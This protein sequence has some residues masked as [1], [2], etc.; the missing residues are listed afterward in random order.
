[1]QTPC[2]LCGASAERLFHRHDAFQAPA[3]FDVYQCANCDTNFAAPMAVDA[4]IYELIYRNA[5][6]VPGYAR[7]ER[8]RAQLKSGTDALGFLSK[9]E[10][11][12][13][14]IAEVLRQ[15]NPQPKS[16][17]RILE[18]G[19]GLGYLTYS[20]HQAG[21]DCRGIDLSAQAV[22]T[23]RSHFGDLYAVSDL[24]ELAKTDAGGYDFLIATELIEH[25]TAPNAFIEQAVR[26]L[27]PGGALIL[28]TPN[29]EMYSSRYVWHTD[30]APVH[31]WWFSKAS[32]RRMAW[33]HGL[34]V[35]F[36]DFSG[37]YGVPA[38]AKHGATKPQTFDQNGAIVFR[39]S[40][41]NTFVRSCLER[42]PALFGLIAKAY[43]SVRALGRM[44]SDRYRESMSLC[45]V[46]Q[47]PGT[48]T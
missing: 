33:Q 24:L 10:D 47:K 26:L 31:L 35:R 43:I 27:K 25:V 20:L 41:F 11:I 17:C 22:T 14:S 32:L 9:Q 3:T 5:S 28:T 18:V 36:V 23:A 1:M 29:K 44:R 7:Y 16:S 15:K 48:D 39:D 8:Y 45:V 34:V 4:G 13:W 6:K 19:S 38:T 21:Y 37:F 46:M 30:P 40:A 12:Y 42:M 2:G